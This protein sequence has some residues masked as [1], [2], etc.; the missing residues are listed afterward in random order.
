MDALRLSWGIFAIFLLCPICDAINPDDWYKGG[1]FYQIYPRYVF[2]YRQ[3]DIFTKEN[4]M[5]AILLNPGHSK[6]VMVM[7]LAI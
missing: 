4:R 6:I 1:N 3:F 5:F 2:I 7:E